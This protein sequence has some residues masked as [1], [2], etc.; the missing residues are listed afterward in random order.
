MKPKFY[1]FYIFYAAFIWLLVLP[2]FRSALASEV[3]FEDNFTSVNPGWGNSAGSFEI[4]D[5]KLTLKPAQSSTRSLVYQGKVFDDAEVTVE[6]TMSAGDTNVP[7]GLVFWAKD[8]S[9]FYCLCI[10]GSGDFKISRYVTDRWLNPVSWTPSEAVNKGVGQVNRLRVVTKGSQATAFI[11]DIQVSAFDGQ[12]PQGGSCVG[13]SGSSPGNSQN[14]WQFARLKVT[15]T[16]VPTVSSPIPQPPAAQPPVAQAPAALQATIS[17]TASPARR[18]LGSVALRLHGSNTIGKDL[19]PALCEDF[20]KF[21]GATSV[22]RKPGTKEDETDIEAVLPSESNKPLT[23]EVQAHGSKRAFEDLAAGACDVGLASRQIKPDEAQQCG[24]AGLGDMFSPVSEIVLGLDGIAVFVN[25]SNSVNELTK[26]QIA[27]IFSGRIA[28]WSQ[29]GG[30]LGPIH[31]YALDENSGTFDIFKSLVLGSGTL[32]PRAV[33]YE[34]SAKL[35]DEVAAD[36]NGIGFAG[37][38]FV[39]GS[40]PLAVSEAGSRPLLPTPFTVATQAYPLSRRL[41]FYLPANPQNKWARKFVDFA[42]SEL[43]GRSNL[44]P[45]GFFARKF[46]ESTLAKLEV[47]SWWTSGGEAAALDALFNIYKKEHPG[48]GII[49][50]TVAGGGGSAARPVLQTRLAIGNPPDTWQSHPGWELLSQYVEP[51]YCEPI[52]DLYRSEGWDKVLPKALIDMMARDGKIYAVL[53]G[54]HRGNVLWYNKRLL[55]KNGIVV[56]E[57]MTFDEFFAACDK[58]KAAG[59]IA[60][61]VGDSGIWASAQL[62][63]NTLLGVVGPQGWMDLFDGK[64]KWDD[65][66]VKLAMQYFAKMQSYLNPDHATL[67]WDQAVKELV[68]GKLAFNSM[69]DWADG[70][71]IKAGMKENEDFG[72]VSYPGTD[73]SFVIVADGFTVAKGAPHKEATIAWLKTIGSKEAQE[74]FNPLKGSIPARIDV[75]KSK[76]DG[77]HQWSMSEFAKDRLLASCV[78]G[79]AAPAAFQQALNDAV[80]SFMVDKNVDNFD[81]ALVQAAEKNAPRTAGRLDL[82]GQAIAIE[83]PTLPPNAPPQFVE[84]VTGAGKLSLSFGFPSRGNQLNDKALEDLDRLVELLA[85]PTYQQRH[86]LLF[87]FSDNSGRNRR[88]LVL[89]KAR[90]QVVAEQLQMRGIAPSLVTGYGKDLPIA[91]NDTE[92]GRAKNRRV[93]VWLR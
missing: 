62:F 27:D 15:A 36:A 40:K 47:F 35:S 61:G 46:I 25:R 90:A 67:T 2:A 93:E 45:T 44:T 63:E 59:I 88:N 18:P 74:A 10:D 31:L 22:Q 16:S 14:T 56:G 48:A 1:I 21:E 78:H 65:P 72:W 64:M 19:V 57:K 70:E 13:V 69:G 9:D 51:N 76:F 73:G 58:L 49:N 54:V 85:N 52:T 3:L 55:D 41:Y 60:L 82:V 75:E 89:S 32:S 86:V 4:K 79:E 68:E 20:L 83:S 84:E 87:G 42:L 38:A 23:F 43:G 30:S 17:P 6:V 91:S 5:D 81:N 53:A 28:D 66:K 8:Y 37:M 12:P 34:N 92:D 50:A 77:Y 71:F 11:N 7:G 33:R 24:L 29:V 39:R 26:Q 80:A